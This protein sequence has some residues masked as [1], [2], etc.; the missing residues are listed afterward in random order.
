MSKDQRLLNH[1]DFSDGQVVNV[2]INSV[3]TTPFWVSKAFTFIENIKII[4]F[5]LQ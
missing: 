3:T 2:K 5:S 4:F 1:L